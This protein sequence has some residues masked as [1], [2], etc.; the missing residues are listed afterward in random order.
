MILPPDAWV[1]ARLVANQAL[2]GEVAA[3][4]ESLRP[5]GE[6]LAPLKP[7]DRPAAWKAMLA[8]RPD[9]DELVKVMAAIDPLGPAPQPQPP[10][11]ATAADIRMVMSNTP[12]RWPGWIRDSSIVGVA[13]LEGTGKT[14]FLLDLMSRYWHKRDHPDGQPIAVAARTPS[15]WICADGHQDEI[16]EMMPQFGLPDEAVIFP[17][18]PDDPYANTSLDSPEALAQID[19]AIQARKPGFVI[20]DSLTYATTRDLCEQRSIAFLKGPLVN[21]CQTHQLNVM[22]SLHV[23]KDGQALGKR[24]KGVTRTLMHLECPDPDQ[25][26]RLRLWIEKTHGKRPPALGVT[27]GDAGN[28]YD[29][30]PPQRADPARAGRPPDK[31]EKAARFILDALARQNDRT[32]NELCREWEKSGENAKTFWRAVDDLANQGD[33][34]TDGG[35]GTRMQKVLHLPSGRDKTQNP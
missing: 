25:P 30:N 11:F 22:L 18:P 34:S 31:R 16:V 10:A 24:I 20:V 13:G 6:H 14:R 4:P 9:R 15:L 27:M 32:G 3:L 19:A 17:A 1:L 2:N 8:A 12:W 28:T 26:E 33:I 35:P 5:M 21:L 23:S 29:F 7:K